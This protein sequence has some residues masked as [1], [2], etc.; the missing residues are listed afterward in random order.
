MPDVA[1]PQPLSEQVEE[2][3]SGMFDPEVLDPELTLKCRYLYLH[4]KVQSIQHRGEEP[5]PKHTELLEDL[6]SQLLD[7]GIRPSNLL[8][9]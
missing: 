9:P 7:A 1:T 2:S 6:E 5:S 3:V 8:K 4:S